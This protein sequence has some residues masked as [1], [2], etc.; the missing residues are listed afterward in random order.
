[1][2]DRACTLLPP[3]LT[4]HFF[5]VF[6]IMA[7]LQL[8]LPLAFAVEDYHD[9]GSYGPLVQRLSGELKVLPEVAFGRSSKEGVAHCF[10]WGVIYKDRK[11]GHVQLQKAL[12]EAGFIEDDDSEIKDLSSIRPLLLAVPTTDRDRRAEYWEMI[13]QISEEQG[14]TKRDA[15]RLYKLANE[16]L[17]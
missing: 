1:M 11:P 17:T 4:P 8:N 12:E 3:P 6:E 15:R 16:T 9:F 7:E 14:V 2:G 5:T 10:Y 13:Q